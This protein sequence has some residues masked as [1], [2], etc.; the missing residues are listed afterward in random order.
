M[1][2]KLKEVCEI[3]NGKDLHANIPLGD[4]LT[5]KPTKLIYV[6]T[7]CFENGRQQK[8]NYYVKEEY[9]DQE[10]ALY[11]QFMASKKERILI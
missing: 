1:K 3:I 11:N 5:D 10:E 9:I 7:S 2:Y 4:I 6:K 8:P